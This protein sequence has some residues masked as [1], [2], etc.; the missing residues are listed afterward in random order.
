M[1]SIGEN[2]D[3]KNIVLAR[4]RCFFNDRDSV[5]DM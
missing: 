3:D 5:L 2:K 4:F 1:E